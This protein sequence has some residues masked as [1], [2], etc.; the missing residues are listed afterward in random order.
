MTT[1]NAASL[2]ALMTDSQ[3]AA[4][5]GTPTLGGE[6]FLG[7]LLAAL[8][9]EA[10][11]LSLQELT[12]WLKQQEDN[13]L[14]V[15]GL[16]MP[17]MPTTVGVP[18]VTEGGKQT[19]PDTLLG[20]IMSSRQGVPAEGGGEAMTALQAAGM[21]DNGGQQAEQA[22]VEQPFK[23][24]LQTMTPTGKL[25]GAEVAEAALRVPVRHPEFGQAV[26]ERLVWLVKNDVQ[27]AKI[28]LDPPNLGPLE[29]NV[30][31]KDDR[32]SI[33]IHAS[34]PVTRDVLEAE[35]PRL[36]GMLGD[37]GFAAIDVNVSRDNSRQ[38]PGGGRPGGGDA[39]LAA[40][41]EEAGAVRSDVANV[42]VGLVDHYA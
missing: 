8:P 32:A 36:R 34:H 39:T 29:I 7:A 25:A 2:A 38:Q 22:V 10:Q 1:M 18:L 16:P 31:V 9:P 19:T 30:S 17:A 5:Q 4:G 12:E 33:L 27:E 15:P 13:G 28:R 20:L 40:E 3:K 35:A 14:G 41:T 42:A 6:G 23:A 21:L 37:N 26:G 11:G 24:L